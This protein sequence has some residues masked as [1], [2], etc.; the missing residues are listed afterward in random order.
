MFGEGFDPGGLNQLAEV[1]TSEATQ[2]TQPQ[3]ESLPPASGCEEQ[4]VNSDG[5]PWEGDFDDDHLNGDSMA[6]ELNKRMAKEEAMAAV[7]RTIGCGCQ[8]WNTK[9]FIIWINHHIMLN[10]VLGASFARLFAKLIH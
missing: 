9:D 4:P 1:A 3:G 7:A 5:T 2:G 6:A 10:L 8:H